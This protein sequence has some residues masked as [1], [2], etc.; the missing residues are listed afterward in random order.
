[1][2]NIARG[3][4]EYSNLMPRTFSDPSNDE[5]Y[6]DYDDQLVVKYGSL[7]AENVPRSASAGNVNKKSRFLHL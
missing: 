5:L 4:N 1:M 6:Q 3:D 2:Y 7:Q